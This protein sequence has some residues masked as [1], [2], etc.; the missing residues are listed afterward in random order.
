MPPVKKKVVVCELCNIPIKSGLMVKHIATPDHQE[1]KSKQF[2]EELKQQQEEYDNRKWFEQ[3]R[4][5]R[6]SH[7]LQQLTIQQQD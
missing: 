2:K 6:M 4:L 7:Q 5:H 3:L 1:L